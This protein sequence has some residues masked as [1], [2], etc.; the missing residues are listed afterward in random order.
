MSGYVYGEGELAT[1]AWCQVWCGPAGWVDMD[2]TR[3]TFV[4]DDHVVIGVGRD[5]LDVPP[6]RGVWKGARGDDP[7]SVQV[8]KIDRMPPDWSE[9][10]IQAPWSPYAVTQFQ[11]QSQ[12][13]S[14]SSRRGKFGALLPSG[15]RQ[16]Q[17]QQQQRQ[18]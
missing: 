6:N 17:S 15:Y 1:H 11:S 4:A 18:S 7:V 10:P 3:G 16:Q 12:S 9:W 5:F 13:Q 14:Q 8:D 2:P